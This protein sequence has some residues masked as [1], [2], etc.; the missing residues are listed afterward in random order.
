MNI[1]EHVSCRPALTDLPIRQLNVCF[2]W[3]LIG[4][5]HFSPNPLSFGLK[6]FLFQDVFG[7]YSCFLL[8]GVSSKTPISGLQDSQ[9]TG[10]A[11]GNGG[12]RG[13]GGWEAGRLGLCGEYAY[14]FLLH[15]SILM[16]PQ[17]S[18]NGEQ[19]R[20]L[21]HTTHGDIH[22]GPAS[23]PVY[24]MLNPIEILRHSQGC[25]M[26]LN[27]FKNVL[28]YLLCVYV[29]W[30]WEY[31]HAMMCWGQKTNF[32]ACKIQWFSLPILFWAISWT[33]GLWLLSRMSSDPLVTTSHFATSALELQLLLP[34]LASSTGPRDEPRV[35]RLAQWLSL[36]SEL[37]H[38]PNCLAAL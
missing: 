21:H 14:S 28:G 27:I 20:M 18:W 10:T 34:P 9:G 26:V 3:N 8:S 31:T 6:Q 33:F 2:I 5:V 12:D 23:V 38:Q 11:S 22:W 37:P 13:L 1:I 19:G 32:M 7:S 30:L 15:E 17:T 25:C 29:C 4:T 16:S 35:T 36:H 24:D